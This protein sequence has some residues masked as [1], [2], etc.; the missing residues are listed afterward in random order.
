MQRQHSDEAE[1]DPIIDPKLA[2][3]IAAN[4]CGI[5]SPTRARTWDLRINSPSIG[6]LILLFHQL[7]TASAQPLYSSRLQCNAGACKTM[8]LHFRIHLR[9]PHPVG[10]PIEDRSWLTDVRRVFVS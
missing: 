10:V 6:S 2:G 7:L 5:G 1:I 8:Q 3:A 9:P 4:Q